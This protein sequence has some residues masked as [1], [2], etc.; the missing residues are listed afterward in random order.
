MTA[1]TDTG[2]IRTVNPATGETIELHPSWTRTDVDHALASAHLALADWGAKPVDE[3]ASLLHAIAGQLREDVE[4]LAALVTT[5]MGKPI[6]EAR[7]EVEKCAW[8]C[9]YYADTGPAELEDHPVETNATRSW[10]SFEPLGVIL[11]IMPWNFPLWQVLRFAA[12]TLLAG[13]TALLKHSPNTTGTAL[14]LD[15]LF[16]AAGV[17]DGVF[18]SLLI[19]EEDV[20]AWTAELVADDRVAGVSLTGSE[21][22]GSSVA[23]IAGRHVKKS[24]LELGGS[25]PFI[26][27]DDANLDE[28]VAAAVRSRFLN[29]GQSCLAAKRFIVQSAVQDAFTARLVEAVEVLV[30]GDPMSDGTQIGPIARDDLVG[31]LRDLV[32]TSIAAGARLRTG[33]A[34]IDRAGSWFQPTVLSDVTVDMPCMVQE[35]FGPVA[36]VITVTDDEA[37][38]DVANATRYGLGASIW[39]ADVDR[40]I[41]LGLR[42]VSGACFVNAVVASDPRLPFGGTKHSGYG[43]ELGAWGIREFVN[44]RTWFVG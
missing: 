37:A 10:V 42:I 26:V 15:R 13:N 29:A 43:R 30:V 5:E 11:A 20:P 35:T 33:G 28:V 18:Q 27:L 32:Q 24:L 21:R 17:P 4:E 41:A 14:A 34:R 16:R 1:A 6:V 8:V 23:C 40:G 2:Y 22:A 7:A 9:D 31:P 12:P 39:T 25:D 3:R 38:V 36:V 19:E 44:T